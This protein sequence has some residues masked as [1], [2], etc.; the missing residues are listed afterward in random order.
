MVCL[1]NG[2]HA[3]AAVAALAAGKHLYLEK[4]LA[5]EPADAERVVR[6]W[7]AA[8]T[9]AMMG[10]NY[11]ANALVEAARAHIGSG[12]IGEV[13]GASTVFTA[14]Q[15]ELP[16]WKRRR[17]SGG[18]ALLDKASHEV[19]VIHCL[20]GLSVRQVS[21]VVESRATEDDNA[22]LTLRLSGGAIAQCYFSLG[23]TEAHRFEVHGTRGRLIVDRLR[24]LDVRAEPPWACPSPLRD[25]AAG[26]R[27]VTRGP[28]GARRILR[29]EHEPSYA[30]SLARFAAAAR[31]NRPARPDL[32]DG[33]RSLAV[34]LAAEESARTGRAVTV[35]EL[36][37]EGSD[38]T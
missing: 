14:A 27:A 21:A 19:D 16:E 20:L 24:S 36:A 7:R 35:P 2:L 4:P 9:V 10:F 3:E 12:R 29:P 1:P 5:T 15:R 8:R 22:A 38:R 11:R 34:V 32:L 18:G 25:L 23:S 30:A 13:L 31:A 17:V 28:F 6:A 37:D 33:Y 26:V